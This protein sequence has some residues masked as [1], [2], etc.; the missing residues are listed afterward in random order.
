MEVFGSIYNFKKYPRSIW[1]IDLK[2]LCLLSLLSQTQASFRQLTEPKFVALNN[3]CP[4][5]GLLKDAFNVV[6][7]L[8]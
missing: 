1:V 6:L 5:S 2:S 3:N 4:W 8:I 7:F